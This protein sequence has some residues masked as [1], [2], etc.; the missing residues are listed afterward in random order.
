MSFINGKIRSIS[1]CSHCKGDIFT[2]SRYVIRRDESGSKY[3]YHDDS[4][5]TLGSNCVAAA[6]IDRRVVEYPKS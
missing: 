4:I 6:G 3:Y 5:P 1:K 2:D